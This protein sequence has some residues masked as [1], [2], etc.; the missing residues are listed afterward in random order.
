[1]WYVNMF[2]Q[3]KLNEKITSYVLT[4]WDVNYLNMNEP[5]C[6]VM[7]LCINYVGCELSWNIV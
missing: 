3:Q 7:T 4:M 5:P 1:M 2:I 6:L